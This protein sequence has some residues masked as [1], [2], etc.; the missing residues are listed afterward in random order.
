MTKRVF[1][2]LETSGLPTMYGFNNYFNYRDLEKYNSSRVVQ[3][4]MVVYE[5]ADRILTRNVIIK[6]KNYIIEN[7]EFHNITHDYAIVNGIE[8]NNLENELNDIFTPDA[9]LIAHNVLF[10]KNVLLSELFRN[11]MISTC[12]KLEKIKV[13]C[14]C[15]SSKN[16]TKIKFSPYSYKLPKLSE[17]YIYLFHKPPINQHD[18]LGDV[19]TLIEIYFELDKRNLL[20]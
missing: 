10:D 12:D 11:N 2:D 13:Y 15:T 16:I 7:S 18:A 19:E 8:L 3:I 5:G 6:P 9:I 14:T 20:I 1:L 4:A 17:L